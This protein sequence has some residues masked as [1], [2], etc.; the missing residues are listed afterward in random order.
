MSYIIKKNEPLVNLKLT[1]TG[2]KNLSSGNLNFSTFQLGDGEMDYS[3]DNPVLINILRPVDKQHDIQ[4]PVPYEG[5]ITQQPISLLTSIQNEV[6]T[7]AK[8]RGFFQF[9]LTTSTTELDSSLWLIGNL[10]GSTHVTSTEI[11]LFDTSRTV[12]NSYRESINAGDFLFLKFKT[13]GYTQ[14]YAPSEN[15]EEINGDPIPY[16]M[17]IIQ[18]IN[19]NS[20]FNISGYT[21]GTTTGFTTGFTTGVTFELD[22]ELPN[23][24]QYVVDGFI[25][26]GKN[27][28]KDYYDNETPIAYWSGGLLDFTSNC[29]LSNDDVPV[30]N[31]NIVTIEDIIGLDSTVYKGKYTAES[32]NYW[33]TAINYDYFLSGNLKDK[34]GVIHYTNNSVS[35]Y[36]AEGFYRNTLKLKLPYLMWHKKQFG[37]ISLGDSIGY[38]FVCDSVLKN[39][40]AGN[41]IR[42]YDLVDQEVNPTVVGKVLIDQKI[43]LIE[44]QELLMAM[45]Y[46]SNRNWTLPT[47]KLTLTEPGVCPGSSFVGSVSPDEAIHIT[48]LFIDTDGITGLHCENYATAKNTSGSVK[49]VVFEFP[50]DPNNPNYSEFSYLYDFNSTEGFGYR[51]GGVILLWQKTPLNGKPNPSDWNFL[52]VNNFIGGNGCLANITSLCDN[53]ELYNETTIYPTSFT[54]DQYTLTEQE[55]GDVIVSQNGLILKQASSLANLGVDGDYYKYPLNVLSGPNNTSIIEFSSGILTSG[56]VIQF[57]YLI[58]ETSTSSTIRQDVTIPIGGIPVGN[59][60]TDGVY[61]IGSTVCLTLNKQPNNNVVYIFYNGQLI[62]A[63]NYGVIP[64]GTTAT[65]RVE[66]TFTP[67]NGSI[68]SLFYLD[69]AGAGNNPISNALTAANIQNLRVNID[70][71][72]LDVSESTIY[73]VNDFILL[74]S[75]SNITGH[76]FGDETFFF[77]N[78]ETDIKA[79]IY[80][81]LITCNVLPNKYINTSNPTFNP[82]QDKVAFTEMGVYDSDGDLVAIGKFSQPLTRKYNS[83]VLIIQATIDF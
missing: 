28:I 8:E 60:Y 33:G 7:A 29:T 9:N 81:S 38:T 25:Y 14:S 16:L 65:R 57:H 34:I 21:T 37:G 12:V 77:G 75:Y 48:Y 30:W 61:L 83:D 82:D 19:G 69:N 74:P 44:D 26:P 43:I 13:T 47:P 55:I 68:I 23:F 1:D 41:T 51:C 73:D 22:R 24:S 5:T 67:S 72:L 39:M 54:S 58:G 76:T 40:G 52:N 80:K 45:S 31:M 49:D 53:F 3:S 11:V 59:D 4:Y 18:S 6:F 62:S 2:R 79:T 32:R 42:Y 78:L 17:Y 63:N 56:D 46:K 10:T 70:K 66:L 50:K 15:T 20:T 36:Y 71:A 35:N 27:T 64:T